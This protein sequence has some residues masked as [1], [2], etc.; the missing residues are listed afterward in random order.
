MYSAPFAVPSPRQ[1]Q[2]ANAY[3]RVGVQTMATS[4]SAHQLVAMLFD[5][6]VAAVQRARGALRAGD[7]VLKCESIGHAARI[8]DEGLKAALNLEA[9]GKLANDLSDLY[10]YVG[11]RL[12]QANLRNDDAALEECLSLMQPVREAWATIAGQP[13]VGN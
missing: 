7:L 10:A 12:T 11:L 1:R 13:A 2:F 4:A 3:Q 6:F 9:G 8:V 5:G